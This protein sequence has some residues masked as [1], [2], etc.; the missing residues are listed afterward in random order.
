[1]IEYKSGCS[2]RVKEKLSAVFVMVQLL[3]QLWW[4]W[5]DD[6]SVSGLHTPQ[7]EHSSLSI[8]CQELSLETPT[9]KTHVARLHSTR[10]YCDDR[11]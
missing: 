2:C 5:R 10:F 7:F 8:V 4:E 11:E 1:M 9:G 6:L 3:R